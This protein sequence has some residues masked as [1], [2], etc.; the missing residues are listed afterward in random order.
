MKDKISQLALMKP[1]H[2]NYVDVEVLLGQDYYHAVRPI[3]VLTGDDSN[4]SCSV[5]LQIAWVIIAS[6]WPS[7]GLNSSCVECI[8]EGSSLIDQT[9]SWYDL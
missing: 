6:L 1:L 9:K 8:D 7:A 5:R 4:S 2:Y 3:D